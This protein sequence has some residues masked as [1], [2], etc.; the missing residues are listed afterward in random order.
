MVFYD[1]P[2]AP[3]PRR[4]RIFLAEKSL[5]IETKS[6]NIGEGEQL[7]SAFLEVNPRG[8][9]PVLVTEAGN[10]LTENVAIAI[11]LEEKFPDPPL[12]GAN[13]EDKAQVL[14]WNAIVE[15]QGGLPIAD[16]LRNSNPHMT[17]RAIAGPVN[18]DQIPA[19]ADR[20]KQR[21]QI[22]YGMLEE[23]LRGREWLAID[24]FSMADITAYVFIEF[25][26]VIK[27][28]IPEEN[29]ASL[30]WMKRVKERPSSNA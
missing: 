10:V 23:Q 1:C 2:T 11:Y 25:A 17:G 28:G 5:E 19:L 15:Q 6:I 26:R 22:F 14:M 8:T 9:V 4:T 27:A 18:F 20:S 30:A 21:V 16:V 29:V 12:L 13:V 7:S 24:Q 3:S